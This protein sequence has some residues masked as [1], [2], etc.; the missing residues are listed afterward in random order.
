MVGIG[1][2]ADVEGAVSHSPEWVKEF[3]LAIEMARTSTLSWSRQ[4]IVSRR[5]GSR[6]WFPRPL[7]MLP[8]TRKQCRCSDVLLRGCVKP[9]TIRRRLD[10]RAPAARFAR[11]ACANF[12]LWNAWRGN[13]NL[14]ELR[15]TLS[16]E[17]RS[18]ELHDIFLG[19]SIDPRP[20]GPDD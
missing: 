18:K 9:A 17:A 16:S 3:G 14:F 4:L 11:A 6:I 13:A 10:L 8:K 1:D 12:T 7:L 20:D 5:A 2:S 19:R 15:A